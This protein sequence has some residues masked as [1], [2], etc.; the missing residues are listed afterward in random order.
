[1]AGIGT[2]ELGDKTWKSLSTEAV[3]KVLWL[4]SLESF[5][6]FYDTPGHLAHC[7]GRE[8]KGRN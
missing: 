8:A 2:W 6:L 4:L 7:P 5:Q 1:M 3:T